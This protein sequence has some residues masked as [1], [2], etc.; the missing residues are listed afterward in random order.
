MSWMVGSNTSKRNV[1]QTKL[2]AQGN[3]SGH[4]YWVVLRH[5]VDFG[6]AV[7]VKPSTALRI[8]DPAHRAAASVGM[9]SGYT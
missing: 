5:K 2:G 4:G 1:V 9:L 6:R 7:K 3:H 8:P